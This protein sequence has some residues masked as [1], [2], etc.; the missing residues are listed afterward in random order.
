[1]DTKMPTEGLENFV[2]KPPSIPDTGDRIDRIRAAV[3][4]GDLA[5]V[6]KVMEEIK[7]IPNGNRF[8]QRPGGPLFKAVDCGQASIVE[9]FFSTGAK[10]YLQLAVIAT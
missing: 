8:L 2:M 6:T 10:F 7:G 3:E 9:Y 5:T 1:M 4:A